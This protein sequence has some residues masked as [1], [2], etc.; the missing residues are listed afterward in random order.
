MSRCGRA[1]RTC[2]WRK[3]PFFRALIAAPASVVMPFNFLQL[4]I[5]AVFGLVLF[6]EMSDLWTWA[7]AVVIFSS[8][9]YI[10]RRESRDARRIAA[11][12][13]TGLGASVLAGP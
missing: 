10:A 4:P 11:E 8:S 3:S 2:R 9:Y 1:S 6:G 5:A 13:Q 12:I 7:G